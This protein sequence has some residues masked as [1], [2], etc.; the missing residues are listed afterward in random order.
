MNKILRSI[1]NFFNL[2]TGFGNYQYH[3]RD[4]Q[5]GAD[6]KNMYRSFGATEFKCK[7][8]RKR[9]ADMSRRRNRLAA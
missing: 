8:K 2:I 4:P 1:N 5:K 7:K 9:I 3:E 6:V